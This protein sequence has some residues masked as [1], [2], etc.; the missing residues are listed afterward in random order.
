MKEKANA[1]LSAVYD[2]LTDKELYEKWKDR[3]VEV[4][5]SYPRLKSGIDA[6]CGSGSAATD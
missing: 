6:A 1:V 3:S 4:L 2:R 5:S